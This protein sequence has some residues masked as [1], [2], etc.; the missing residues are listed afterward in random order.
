MALTSAPTPSASPAPPPASSESPDSP[1]P[2]SRDIPFRSRAKPLLGHQ[3]SVNA[4]SVVAGRIASGGE[5]AT[6]RLWA[7]SGGD[8]VVLTHAK[9]LNAL[10]L[11]PDGKTL[12]TGGWN[13]AVTLWKTSS[14]EKL[15][16]HPTESPIWSIAFSPS[17]KHL[18]VGTGY[19]LLLLDVDPAFRVRATLLPN[20]HLVS[21]VAFSADGK[22]L[23]ACTYLRQVH[24]WDVATLAETHV[25]GFPEE[26]SSVAMTAN[27]KYIAFSSR[28]GRLYVWQPDL[29]QSPRQMQKVGRSIKTMTFLPN[30]DMLLFT[31]E[32]AG[33]LRLLDAS[34]GSSRDVAI[35]V[36]KVL[37]A[38]SVSPDGKLFATGGSDGAVRVW[39]IVP[40]D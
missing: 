5:D 4:V 24:R 17:G 6:A 15:I 21:S 12:A 25:E 10:A 31:G 27:G 14:G 18:A 2:L 30:R 23:A 8:P 37:N 1:K 40:Q 36:P 11:S 39:D 26:L 35:N 33:P 9:A 13:K 29:N 38:V 34:T 16:E 19:E 22:Y 7:I 3:G 28:I 32:W 20:R